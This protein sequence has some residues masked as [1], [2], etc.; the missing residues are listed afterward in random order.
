MIGRVTV[1]RDGFPQKAEVVIL[2]LF[3]NDLKKSNIVKELEKKSGGILADKIKRFEFEAKPGQVISA[4]NLSSYKR[5]YLLGLGGKKDFSLIRLREDLAKVLRT[6]QSH[7]FSSADIFLPDIELSFQLGK[8][9]GLAVH[10]TNYSFLKYK[11]KEEIK[12]HTVIKDAVIFV[13]QSAK[14]KDLRLME[15]GLRVA[16]AL[17]EGITL[18]RDLVNEPALHLGPDEMVAVARSIEKEAKGLLKV[19]VLD[20][21]EC[22]KLGMGAFLGVAQGS[23]KKPKFIVIQTVSKKAAKKKHVSIV[24]KTIMF[25][26]GGLSLK[27]GQSMEDMKFDM[28]GGAAVLGAFKTL[29]QTPA[30][31]KKI[32]DQ[33]ELTGVIPA[34]ENMPSGNALRPG[35]IVRALN[36]KTIE[37][38]NTDAEGRL[39]LADTLSYAEKHLKAEY[40]ID[41]ATLTGACMVALGNDLAGAFGNDKEFKKLVVDSAKHEGEGIW[42]LPLHKPYLK[43]MKSDIADL[44]NI[45]GGRYGGAITA[46]LFLSE[47]VKKAKWVHLDIAGPAFR[48]EPPKGTRPKGASGWGV[49]TVLGVVT[50]LITD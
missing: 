44:K 29:I 6:V 37:V 45:G 17:R 49:M 47:F 25:D 46:A 38:L 33:M 20:E 28:A 32:A 43:Q 3:Q 50:Q 24:G 11:S 9:A 2:P 21:N 4:E 22:R 7:R 30:F 1:R 34:C 42:P 23:D 16:D 31:L 19:K 40:I 36:G 48:H 8:H 27:P 14:E 35:D 12:K 5:V 39:V 10:L 13:N 18:T 26:S 15:E 41:L